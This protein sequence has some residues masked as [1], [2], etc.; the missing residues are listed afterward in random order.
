MSETCSGSRKFC[1]QQCA[2]QALYRLVKRIESQIKWAENY[3]REHA[4][5]ASEAASCLTYRDSLKGILRDA[6]LP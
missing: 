2:E 5:T 3:E 6:N 1:C 4:V